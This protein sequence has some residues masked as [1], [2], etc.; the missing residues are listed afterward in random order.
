MAC[1]CQSC[2]KKFKVDIMIPDEVWEIIKPKG[3]PVGAGLLCGVCILGRLEG[4]GYGAFELI[5]IGK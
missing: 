1:K 5:D 4:L 3:K 2:E